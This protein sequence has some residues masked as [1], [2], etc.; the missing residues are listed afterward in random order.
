MYATGRHPEQRRY[1]LRRLA[2]G[3]CSLGLVEIGIF[4]ASRG[5][6]AEWSAALYA[7]QRR[8]KKE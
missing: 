8:L 3:L 7:V 4:A 2:V 5:L 6:G 1:W